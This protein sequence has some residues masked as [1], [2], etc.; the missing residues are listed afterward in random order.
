[1]YMFNN[2]LPLYCSNS[3]VTLC[4]GTVLYCENEVSDVLEQK[5]NGDQVILIL[6]DKNGEEKS[7]YSNEIFHIEYSD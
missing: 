6:S 4:D 5:K 7:V 3:I 1:M 2:G